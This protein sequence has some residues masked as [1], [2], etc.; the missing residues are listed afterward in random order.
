MKHMKVTEL[1]LHPAVEL[2]PHMSEDEFEMLKDDIADNGIQEPVVVHN[3]TILDGRHRFRAAKELKLKEI[4]VTI[5]DKDYSE[6]DI[7]SLVLSLNLKRRHLNPGQRTLI[8][9]DIN[10]GKKVSRDTILKLSGVGIATLKRVQY[11]MKHGTK[12]QIEQVRSGSELASTVQRYIKKDLPSPPKEAKKAKQGGVKV[13]NPD[14]TP[15]ICSERTVKL[16]FI[17]KYGSH[18]QKT[19]MKNSPGNVNIVYGALKKKLEGD[20]PPM[21]ALPPSSSNIPPVVVD[22]EG[23]YNKVYEEHEKL[24]LVC[25]GLETELRHMTE[26]ADKSMT[27]HKMV[28]QDYTHSTGADVSMRELDESGLRFDDPETYHRLVVEHKKFHEK[29]PRAEIETAY[30][31]QAVTLGADILE[32]NKIS[33]KILTGQLVLTREDIEKMKTKEDAI[34]SVV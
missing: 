16:A 3:N 32:I 9:M 18:A 14:D 7:K 31:V 13:N 1:K 30:F 20:V 25:M 26:S 27:D 17:E 2:L 23:K 11:I 8:V 4:P 33:R 10:E 12:E 21:S 28:K 6:E 29:D 5:E 34:P 15:E 22:W 24:I 19:A